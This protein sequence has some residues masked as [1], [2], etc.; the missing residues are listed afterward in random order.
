MQRS[1][2]IHDEDNPVTS[3][4][5]YL[6]FLRRQRQTRSFSEEPVSDVDLDNILETIRWTGSSG[7]SQ[8]W[9]FL[10]VREPETKARLAALVEWTAWI[11]GAS[12]IIFVLT[13]GP[14]PRAH[15]Y[16]LGRVDERILLA[17]Q[18]LGLGA[19]VVTPHTEE[20]LAGARA[21]LHVPSDWSIYSAVAIGHPD[22][23]AK[24]ASKGGRKP[25]E[26]LVDWELF[27]IKV[28]PG[29]QV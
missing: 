28:R 23:H 16:D 5:E 6:E 17:S 29:A 15:T 26:E 22:E 2:P 13:E 25:L 14:D 3:R 10:V 4:N 11:A 21:I 24:P 18:A 8:P 19:G 12:A 9:K 27:G 1:N 7:N 20:A